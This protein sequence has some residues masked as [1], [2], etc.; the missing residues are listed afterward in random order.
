MIRFFRNDQVKQRLKIKALSEKKFRK[1]NRLKKTK[2]LPLLVVIQNW[3]RKN[4]GGRSLQKTQPARLILFLGSLLNYKVGAH[5][6][7]NACT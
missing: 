4:I 3:K 5:T 7:N 6:A 2:R 1:S